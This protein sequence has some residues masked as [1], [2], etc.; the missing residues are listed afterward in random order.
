ME[1]EK[2]YTVISHGAGYVATIPRWWLFMNSILPGA[3]LR[4]RLGKDY[5]LII[6]PVMKGKPAF[7]EYESEEYEKG[8]TQAEEIARR[9]R[10]KGGKD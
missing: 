10:G 5:E 6:S 7:P 3:K 4:Y 2:L 9:R 8:E 1:V